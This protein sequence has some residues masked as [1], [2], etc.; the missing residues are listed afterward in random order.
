[1][2][3]AREGEVGAHGGG[4]HLLLFPL[5]TIVSNESN[6]FNKNNSKKEEEMKKFRHRRT[7][8]NAEN[9]CCDVFAS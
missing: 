8:R 6:F 2:K 9:Q 5:N 1:M 3:T 4:E 7:A